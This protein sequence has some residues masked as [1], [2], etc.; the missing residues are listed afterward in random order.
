MLRQIIGNGVPA[1]I[2]NSI[3]SV[4][5]VFVQSNINK[6]GATAVAGCGSY[7]K[8]EGSASCP[9]PV[10][11]GADDLYQPEP[12][13]QGVRA[14]EERRGVRGGLLPH[15]GGAYRPCHQ[16]AGAGP[17]RRFRRRGGGGGLRRA[18]GPDRDLVLFPPGLLPLHGG[19]AAG[20]RPVRGAHARD[21]GLLVRDPCELH[22][23]RGAHPAG[24]PGDLLGVP[25]DVASELR[26]LSSL[27]PQ[28][29]LDPRAGAETVVL[30][31]IFAVY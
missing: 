24:H 14:G 11:P 4:A 10:R 17:D 29:G 7:S 13:R 25:H 18:V 16:P 6:F 9:S 5:N 1:G 12:G 23:H 8:I 22:Q 21:D 3:I 31:G 26:G 27:L 19:R 28:V 15:G 20:C 30:P 2:Q